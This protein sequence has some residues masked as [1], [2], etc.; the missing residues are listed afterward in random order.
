MLLARSGELCVCELMIALRVPQ[1]KM[2]RH[3]AVL[4]ETGLVDARRDRVWIHYRLAGAF[5]AWA[6]ETIHAVA[7]GCS[8]Q[9]PFT[10]DDERL[11]RMPDRPT[12]PAGVVQS[13]RLG[14][15]HVQTVTRALCLHPQRLPLPD[16][17]A[18]GRVRPMQA[19]DMHGGSA[20]SGRDFCLRCCILKLK[21]TLQG[22]S[23][24]PAPHRYHPPGCIWHITHR[25]HQTK[26]VSAQV[27]ARSQ[28]LATRA[29]RGQEAL[30]VAGSQ[31]HRDV[32]SRPLPGAS[33]GQGEI[34]PSVQLIAGRTDQEFN[35]CG[36]KGRFGKTATVRP[37]WTAR[38]IGSAVWPTST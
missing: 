1:P 29:V 8:H 24:C 12:D 25:C 27:H 32:Q 21:T 16:G 3:L 35:R 30:R 9:P 13:D 33:R 18:K 10:Q 36:R 15:T 23:R 19:I 26:G 5:P 14:A 7:D 37:P 38:V 17:R 22:G 20:V 28:A 34:A 11:Q 2:S 6:R 4:R 31:L